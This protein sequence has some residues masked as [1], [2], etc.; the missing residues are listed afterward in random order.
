M[1]WQL[2][3][4]FALV[5]C[6]GFFV[7]SEFALV[8]VRR[9]RIDQLAAEGSSAAATVQRALRQLTRYIAATQI[10]VTIASLVLGGLGEQILEPL[11][12]GAFAAL[13]M[14]VR[15]LFI[16]RTAIAT[17]F[18][19]FIMT[20]MH[21]V[22]GELLPKNISLHRTER[23]ALILMRPM[24]WFVFIV[25]PLI[26]FLNGLGGL[27]LKLLGIQS[28]DAHTQVHSPEEL[29]L[30]FT[31]S[32]EGGQLNKTEFELLHR[33][34]RFSDLTAREVMV[35][36]VEV[37]ALPLEIE[38]DALIAFL[39]NR[40]HTRVP[41]YRG[42]IDEVVGIA[43]LK[44]LLQ[45]GA[46]LQ[47]Q[48][49]FA[50]KKL[51]Q[52]AENMAEQYRV[53]ELSGD[54][55]NLRPWVR[56]AAR[57]PETVTIDKLLLEFKRRRQQMAIV[58]DEYGGT[59]GLVTMGDLLEQ[60]FGDVH[61]EFDRP[62]PDVVVRGEGQVWLAG[63]TLIEEVNDRFGV[64]FRSDEA[65]T[66]AGLVQTALGQPG[67]VGDEVTINHVR[68]KVESV[69][70]LRITGLLMQLPS[71]DKERVEATATAEA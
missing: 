27:L 32:H 61:D 19:Y 51:S 9:T 48:I 21:V 13:G 66:V 43:H 24:S 30:I 22:V 42:T 50:D 68:L 49:N 45:V 47:G 26:W 7:A 6:N 71:V 62:E 69:D 29:D 40:P 31:Q 33:V 23:V 63:R 8:S 18:A 3:A 52:N 5:L 41:I 65:D 20:T 25:T 54:S 58:I 35:P 12:H 53:A 55:I 15:L 60:V 28:A 14:P 1:L 57:V 39:H 38:R 56:E 17:G 11:F 2:A 70:R 4:V 44:D 36:R 34:V 37:Q 16:S 67:R 46:A 59:S 10:G 64:G